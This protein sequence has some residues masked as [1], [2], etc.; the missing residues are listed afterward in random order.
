MT[1]DEAIET[2]EMHLTAE[3]ALD[4]IEKAEALRLGNEALKA[5]KTFRR[6]GSLPDP[7]LL[8]GET[9]E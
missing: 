4:N 7:M 5:W 8:P 3:K 1:L 6:Y 2:N 9:Q